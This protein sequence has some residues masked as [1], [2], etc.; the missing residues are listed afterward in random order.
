MES[1]RFARSSHFP[2]VRVECRGCKESSPFGVHE[3]GTLVEPRIRRRYQEPEAFR[4]LRISTPP[5][6]HVRL[7]QIRVDGGV[8]YRIVRGGLSRRRVE[9]EERWRAARSNRGRGAVARPGGWSSQAYL[10][11][12]D[13]V[14]ALGI[15][16]MQLAAAAILPRSAWRLLAWPRQASR[17]CMHAVVVVDEYRET[18]LDSLIL[19]AASLPSPVVGEQEQ[20]RRGGRE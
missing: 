14:R 7:L 11:R 15:R 20:R 1:S 18:P 19:P 4:L 2:F 3:D 5:R 9:G 17:A 16:S 8:L 10:G 12:N 6:T 13:G